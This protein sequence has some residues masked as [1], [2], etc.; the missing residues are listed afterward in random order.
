MWPL[1]K[2]DE[3]GLQY[4]V[5]MLL[6]NWVI[7]F[8]PFAQ[9][10]SERKSFIGWT[11]AVSHPSLS[12]SSS[13]AY[14]HHLP[15]VVHLAILALHFLELALPALLPTLTQRILARYPDI[16]AVLNVL[17]CA[18]VLGLIWVWSLK[19]Q[20]LEVGVACGI[21]PL[22][23]LS[24]GSGAGK[25]KKREKERREKG[26]GKERDRTAKDTL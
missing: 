2:R 21:E 4:L 18:P 11:S 19:R 25:E 22:G 14:S 7:G 3:L 15:Q 16:W 9:L 12:L 26:E 10:R 23:F 20:L 17:L 13:V 8:Q 24:V 6:W 5:L 1:L